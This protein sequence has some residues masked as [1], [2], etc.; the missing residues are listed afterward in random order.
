MDKA[1]LLVLDVETYKPRSTALLQLMRNEAA[2][3]KKA[4][5]YKQETWDA[6]AGERAAKAEEKAATDIAFAEP[7][8]VAC[9]ADDNH[10][11]YDIFD[12]NL[13]TMVL[14][15]LV[16]TLDE[17][18]GPDTVWIGHNVLKFDFPLLLNCWRRNRITPPEHFPRLRGGYFKGRV[19]DTMKEFPN[20]TGYISLS[21]ACAILGVDGAKSVCWNGIPITGADVGRL[22]DAGMFD[23][24]VEYGNSDVTV[25]KA[26]YMAMTCG[27]SYGT[28]DTFQ[29]TRTKV[30]EIVGTEGLADDAK[31][32]LIVA[33]LKLAGLA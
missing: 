3:A 21:T 7:L 10:F 18:T 32:L 5:N 9:A 22:Y 27:D 6:K 28:Y 15:Q 19:Y 26:L 24:L 16:Y 30:R 23:L 2:G 33:T 8:M 13:E 29:D 20:K 12:P 17:L 31:Y 4:G 14:E 25:E 11:H 1:R